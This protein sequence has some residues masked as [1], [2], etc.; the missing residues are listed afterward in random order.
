[1]QATQKWS[2]DKSAILAILAPQAASLARDIPDAL[3]H[4]KE[5]KFYGYQFPLPDLPTWF[6][7]YHGN[8]NSAEAVIDLIGQF[9]DY[10]LKVG[11]VGETAIDFQESIKMNP[12]ESLTFSP[13]LLEKFNFSLKDLVS[14][15]NAEL[16]DNFSNIPFDVKTKAKFLKAAKK[17]ETEIAFFFFV[18]TPCWLFFQMSP[19]RLYRK[20]RRG[21]I[22]ALEKLLNLDP[23]LLHDP[24]IGRAIQKL[25]FNNK[26][27][28]YERILDAG[29]KP[30]K[31]SLNRSK[32]KASFSAY[33]SLLSG[34]IN[35]PLLE[36][37][38]RKLHDAIN[39]DAEGKEIDTDLPDSSE[40]FAKAIQRQKPKWQ[41]II[42]PDK[43]K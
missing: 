33:L 39:Q 32:I 29:R 28:D 19:N 40:T 3:R 36:P 41:Q 35:Q 10:F 21:D 34:I 14:A 7:L 4:I 12:E 15:S 38:L 27:K 42:H 9:S 26:T 30:L 22:S 24:T 5:R 25:R 20:A 17:N 8:D 11:A 43:K 31:P 18:L 1:M 2:E 16:K 13:E 6:N 23:L 37:Q